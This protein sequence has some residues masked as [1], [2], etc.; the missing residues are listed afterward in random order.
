MHNFNVQGGSSVDSEVRWVETNRNQ[1]LT[2]IDQ[3]DD[4]GINGSIMD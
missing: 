4:N 3:A 2:N 1:H